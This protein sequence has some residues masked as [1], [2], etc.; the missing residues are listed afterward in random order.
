VT[1]RVIRVCFAADDRVPDK[2]ASRSPEVSKILRART[3]IARGGIAI[4]PQGGDAS[5][6]KVGR[7]RR[8][9]VQARPVH[10]G[11]RW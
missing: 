3:L 4:R 5:L 7:D 10:F 6:Q 8:A 1:G 11:G 9:I 2:C